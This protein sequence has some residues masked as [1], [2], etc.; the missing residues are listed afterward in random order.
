MII[1]NVTMSYIH[2]AIKQY[3][4]AIYS[5]FAATYTLHTAIH[6]LPVTMSALNIAEDIGIVA[7]VAKPV[8]ENS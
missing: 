5:S 8:A 7:E 2:F 4:Q 3:F 1:K 6:S